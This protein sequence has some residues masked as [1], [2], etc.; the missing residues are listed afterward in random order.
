MPNKKKMPSK[1]PNKMPNKKK[2]P[3]KN[4]RAEN[5]RQSRNPVLPE[6]PNHKKSSRKRTTTT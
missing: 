3:N 1:M 6:F 5:N 2:M 4:S